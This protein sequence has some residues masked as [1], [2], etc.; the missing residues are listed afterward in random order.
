M[1][2]RSP[3]AAAAAAVAVSLAV[4]LSPAP[5][6]AFQERAGPSVE[7]AG[8]PTPT[9]P[10]LGLLDLCEREPQVCRGPGTDT[11][12]LTR[13]VA[14]GREMAWR[15]ILSGHGRTAGPASLATRSTI[16]RLR[17]GRPGGGFLGGLVANEGQPP[18]DDHARVRAVNAA[19]N[20][21][22][23]PVSD[24]RLH[25]RAD[26]W[27]LPQPD[28][29][30]RLAGDCEDYVLAKREALLRAGVAERR[31]SIALAHT[32]QGE[33][34]AVLL[35]AFPDADYVLDNR[36]SRVLEWSRS[37]LVWTSR[38]RPGDLFQWIRL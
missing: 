14:Q 16:R 15:E 13:S 27:S 5:A 29:K 2:N 26:V 19:I 22:V 6:L 10:P 3:A 11:A 20:A 17:A 31:L 7:L 36:D 35:V 38:Q 25:G 23:T 37:D 18:A 33:E 12:D 4:L 30:G 32:P 9:A 34:H 24:L 28:P 21:R 8:V 1:S